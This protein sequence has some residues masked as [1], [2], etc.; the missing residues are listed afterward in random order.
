MDSRTPDTIWDSD[1][2]HRREEAE[3]LIEFLSSKIDERRRRGGKPTYVL[4]IDAAWGQGKT[5][6]L[7]KLRE[8][9]QVQGYMVATVN[10]WKDDHAEDAFIA[11]MSAIRAEIR[12]HS[13]LATA[14]KASLVAASL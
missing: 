10:A 4:N 12:K 5:F 1:L 14:S 7:D 3:F 8:T 13:K 11:V 2:L 6:F 9:L